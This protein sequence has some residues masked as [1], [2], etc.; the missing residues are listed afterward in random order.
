VSQNPVDDRYRFE[1]HDPDD[2]EAFEAGLSS[3]RFAR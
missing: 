1:V 3:P 2:L